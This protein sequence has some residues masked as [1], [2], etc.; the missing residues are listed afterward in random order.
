M[1]SLTELIQ[2]VAALFSS[3]SADPLASSVTF[4]PAS[5][6]GAAMASPTEPL[7]RTDIRRT[8]T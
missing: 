5:T 3:G 1:S 7:P 6:K 8:V 4:C 2:K